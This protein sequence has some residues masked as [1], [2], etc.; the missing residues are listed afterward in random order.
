MNFVW[1]QAFV[2]QILF[3]L[4][5]QLKGNRDKPKFECRFRGLCKELFQ[6]GN[7]DIMCFAASLDLPVSFRSPKY[8]LPLCDCFSHIH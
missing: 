3:Y 7:S 5:H 4:Q 8:F 1:L 2:N 6:S